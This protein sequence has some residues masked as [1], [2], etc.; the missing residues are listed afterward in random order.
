MRTI[1]LPMTQ[2]DLIQ[3]AK[4][5]DWQEFFSALGYLV[6]WNQDIYPKV[7]IERDG[8]TDLL[9]NYYRPD[10]NFGYALGAVWHDGHYGIYS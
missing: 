7:V 3:I 10:G 4:A 8:E 5:T 6:S 1:E 2:D 9:A